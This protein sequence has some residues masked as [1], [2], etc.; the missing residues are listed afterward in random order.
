[1]NK[2]EPADIIILWCLLHRRG[3]KK[4]IFEQFLIELSTPRKYFYRVL[5]PVL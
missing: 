2:I 4:S 5:G 3:R 1:M